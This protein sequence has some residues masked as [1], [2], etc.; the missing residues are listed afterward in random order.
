MTASRFEL[1]QIG[2]ATLYRGDCREVLAAIRSV[3]V[4]VTDPPYDVTPTSITHYSNPGMIKAGW[5]GTSYP[6]NHGKMFQVPEFGDWMGVVFESCAADAD[7]YFMSNDKVLM[8]MRSAAASAGWKFHN[9]LVWQ[10]PVG[11]P[12]RWYFKD[13]EFALYMWRGKA[14][15]IRQ[16][17]SCQTFRA[18]H[19]RDRR[20]VSQ[21]P[22]ELIAHYVA[23]SSDLG[24]LVLDPF[25]GVGTTGVAC[26]RLGR[27][28]VGIE[29]DADYFRIACERIEAAYDQG[30][31]FAAEPRTE[32]QAE[33]FEEGSQWTTR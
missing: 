2:D 3:D 12:N 14:K 16:P 27:R 28:F 1:V 8:D 9:L 33:L 4:V 20:H 18:G 11:I 5:M 23:N 30:D 25:M 17:S 24:D 22:V 26:A 21:K 7:A 10:K 6:A 13:C 15:T 31:L 32:S 19:V 29:I